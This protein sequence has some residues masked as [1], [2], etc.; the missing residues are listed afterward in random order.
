MTPG[1]EF[2]QI[3]RGNQFFAVG[4]ETSNKTLVIENNNSLGERGMQ[5]TSSSKG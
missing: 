3:I 4:N 5:G 1:V 2:T